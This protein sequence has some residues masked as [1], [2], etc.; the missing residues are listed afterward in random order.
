MTSRSLS[1][2]K[3]A[4]SLRDRLRA[5]FWNYWFR[6]GGTYSIAI[7]RV[8][9]FIAVYVTLN[10][11]PGVAEPVAD[12]YD[13]V[14]WAS[15]VPKGLVKVLGSQPPSAEF[16]EVVKIIARYSTVLAIFGFLTRLN[17]I[18][19]TLSVTFLLGLN[20][21]F[22]T[23]WSHTHNVICLAALAFMFGRAGDVLSIDAAI[24]AALKRSGRPS[25][26][27]DG[28]YMWPILL[29]QAAVAL[30]YLGAFFAKFAG[31]H[32]TFNL[33][34]IFSDSLR[35]AIM[36]P[37]HVADRP[38]PSYLEFIVSHPMLWKLVAFG[39]LLNQFIVI[40]ACF[41]INRPWLR[42]MEGCIFSAGVIFLGLVMTYW[43]L[44]WLLVMPFFID[45]DYF[46]ALVRRALSRRRGSAAEVPVLPLGRNPDAR[47]CPEL[48]D[49]PRGGRW[50]SI[51]VAGV[52]AY[53]TA[54]LGLHV[55][56]FALQFGKDHLLY[57]FS[58]L[59]F[60]AGVKAIP[61]LD[62]HTDWRVNL[63]QVSLV[64]SDGEFFIAPASNMDLLSSYR[65][66]NKQRIDGSLEERVSLTQA[67][68]N[69]LAR[70]DRFRL[71][72]TDQ[73]IT[74]KNLSEVRV[75]GGRFRFPAYP[76]PP[77]WIVDDRWLLGVYDVSRATVISV[78]STY[79]ID[80]SSG[81]VEVD[82]DI[83]GVDKP[84]VRVLYGPVA[85][86]DNE[87]E[88][89]R[90]VRGGTEVSP[91]DGTGFRHVRFVISEDSILPKGRFFI[92]VRTAKSGRSYTFHGPEFG[93]LTHS[94]ELAS[95]DLSLPRAAVGRRW[96]GVYSGTISCAA[97][98][99]SPAYVQRRIVDV[100]D[101]RMEFRSNH[102]GI[103]NG[104]SFWDGAI[105]P[106][107]RLSIRG[108]YY[109]DRFKIIAFD[110]TVSG[111]RIVARGKQGPRDCDLVFEAQ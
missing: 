58:N 15:Y 94:P 33:D 68:A 60:F 51:A 82:V 96:D 41:A 78:D 1:S 35:N 77:Q 54:F 40:H 10:R 8:F 30:F 53:A 111:G 48:G 11:L 81:R 67:V 13:T 47:T 74:P 31:P 62:V 63:A 38:L 55:S 7:I 49:R 110:G 88:K 80:A 37:W 36:Q 32:Y 28:F 104:Y 66:E 64:G 27:H 86:E 91:P 102:K 92:N 79:R 23:Y 109:W 72:G 6:S 105:S 26:T 14:S 45:W 29:G 34:W 56:S 99:S 21:S 18:V 83:A 75:W 106:Q 17:M 101:S 52:S 73:F 108:A 4:V 69:G 12:W 107:G 46:I 87:S 98:G 25:E 42:L 59:D 71:L 50:K 57:P 100:I 84:E 20:Y 2:R 22:V 19:S 24:R 65:F 103:V 43:N 16:V 93:G 97:A 70:V 95:L 9:L 90:V 61:P 44:H 76:A 39:H 85:G 3:L 5:G 89:V